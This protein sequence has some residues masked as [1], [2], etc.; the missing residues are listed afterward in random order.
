MRRALMG[1][2]VALVLALPACNPTYIDHDY[3][4][5][6]DFNR[7]R[8]FAWYEQTTMTEG[9]PQAIQQSGLLEARI[10]RAVTEGLE[11]KGLTLV[12]NDPDLL[13]AYHIGVE[14]ITEIRTTGYGYG[15]SGHTRSDHFQEGTFILDLIDTS[16]DKLVWRGTAEGVLEERPTPEQMERDVNDTVKRLLLNYPPSK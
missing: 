4:P 11:K 1:I 15:F 3:D 9:T 5:D 7:F 6:V 2:A 12:E 8:T 13:I 14:N 10:Q 16:V